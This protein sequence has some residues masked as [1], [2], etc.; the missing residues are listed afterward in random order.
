MHVYSQVNVDMFR[1]KI[2]DTNTNQ[3]RYVT[4]CQN[5]KIWDTTIDP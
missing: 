1:Y 4:I 2:R 5:D 3:V